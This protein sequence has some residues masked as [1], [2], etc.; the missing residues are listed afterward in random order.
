MKKIIVLA[1]MAWGLAA[2]NPTQQSDQKS[3]AYE[4]QATTSQDIA[5]TDISDIKTEDVQYEESPSDIT[6]SS[7][8]PPIELHLSEQV[9]Q[10]AMGNPIYLQLDLS[11]IV[12]DVKIY[13]VIVNR[14]NSCAPRFWYQNWQAMAL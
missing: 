11:A 12:D 14:G 7:D 9:N 10:Y 13:D 6:Q 1:F 8:D 2:C 4:T 3:K 5:S